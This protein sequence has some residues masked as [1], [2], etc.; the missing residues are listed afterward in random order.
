MRRALVDTPQARPLCDGFTSQ[1]ISPLYCPVL[2][3]AFRFFSADTS[4]HTQEWLRA[5][6][7]PGLGAIGGIDRDEPVYVNSR[8]CT[9][10][11]GGAIGVF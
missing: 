1:H 9:I 6:K 8:W 4:M 10:S 7:F 2:C 11:V 5:S 3:V